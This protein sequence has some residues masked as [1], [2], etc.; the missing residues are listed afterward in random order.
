LP[1]T[2][3]ELDGAVVQHG[4]A[5]DRVYVMQLDADPVA[6]VLDRVDALALKEG[7]GKVVVKARASDFGVFALRGYRAEAVVPRFY[8]PEETGVFMG[9]FLDR[10]RITDPREQEVSEVIRTALDAGLEE[11][12]DGAVPPRDGAPPSLVAGVR[13]REAGPADAEALAD[14]Y[15]SVFESYPFPIDEAAHL[16]REMSRGTR[17]FLATEDGALV[18]ASSMEPGGAPGVVE[19]T[20]FATLPSQRGRGLATGL[21]ALMDHHARADGLRVAYTIARAASFGMNITFAR[22][23]YRYGGTLV[24]NT[25]IGGTIESMNVWY[26]LLTEPERT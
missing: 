15:A 12:V 11:R 3:L 7:Y 25:Q 19:M 4:P 22:R 23:G 10:T 1:D 13:L 20:D 14:C 9:R 17:F 24:N 2:V 16:R 6:P 8:G 26:K 21:L 5:S 18:A